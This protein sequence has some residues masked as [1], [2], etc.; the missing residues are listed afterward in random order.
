MSSRLRK[1]SR[2]SPSPLLAVL[3]LS[4][5]GDSHTQV[6]TGTYA[7][8]SG[9]NAPYLNVGP[10]VYEVQLSRE[11][12]PAE[13]RRRRLPAGAHARPAPARSR[14][15]VV[16]GVHAGLQPPLRPAAGGDRPDDQRHAEQHLHPDRARCR[17]TNSPTAAASSR[18]KPAPGARVDRQPRART[19]G[20]LL[21]YKIQIVSLDNRPL[22]LKIVDPTERLRRRPQPSSTSDAAPATLAASSAELVAA[23]PLRAPARATGAAV[24]PPAPS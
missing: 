2:P 4:A 10:L 12:N 24:A 1:S 22:E 19:Q 3:A 17:P 7:G 8:E 18:P 6:T 20:A 15:G 9:Q 21:L 13:R 11:L 16:R 14:S 5:C 23:V